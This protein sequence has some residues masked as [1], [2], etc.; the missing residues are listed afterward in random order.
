[1]YVCDAFMQAPAAV[2]AVLAKPGTD[3]D[4]AFLTWNHD[5]CISQV[6]FKG[7]QDLTLWRFSLPCRAEALTDWLSDRVCPQVLCNAPN[8]WLLGKICGPSLGLLLQA[9][10]QCVI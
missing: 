9:A 1:M 4:V 7:L 2:D 8:P 10:G 5:S 6:Q 3:N